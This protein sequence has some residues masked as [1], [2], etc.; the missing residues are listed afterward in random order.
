MSA[1]PAWARSAGRSTTSSASRRRPTGS[2]RR[3]LPSRRASRWRGHGRA[4]SEKQA[5]GTA[6]N[7]CAH[8]FH[9]LHKEGHIMLKSNSLSQIFVLDQDQALEFYVG[10]LGL[11][12]IG[13]A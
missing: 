11:E 7:V 1:S 4:V 2:A 8:R 13:R 3:S 5:R 12:E 6:S 10:K 9:H